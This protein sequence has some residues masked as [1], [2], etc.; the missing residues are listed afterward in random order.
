[1]EIKGNKIADEG[2][3]QGFKGDNDN[4]NLQT[5]FEG[6]TFERA[7]LIDSGGKKIVGDEVPVNSKFTIEIDGVKNFTLAN[8][9]AFPQLSLLVTG[10]KGP[11]VKEDNLLG[12][13][14]QGLSPEDASTLHGTVNVGKPMEIGKQ[15]ACVIKITDANNP[16]VWIESSWVF[17]VK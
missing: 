16:N 12:S 10:D 17:T 14:T 2:G 8:G 7:Q 9:K 11:V 15:Y 4:I 6:L 5:L 13:N 1:M 3:A